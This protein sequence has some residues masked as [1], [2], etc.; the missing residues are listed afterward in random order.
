MILVKHLIG[1]DRPPTDGDET[2]IGSQSGDQ[3]PCHGYSCYCLVI[4]FLHADRRTEKID[5]KYFTV[6]LFTGLKIW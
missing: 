6:G 4:D 2:R 5:C 3:T 1:E